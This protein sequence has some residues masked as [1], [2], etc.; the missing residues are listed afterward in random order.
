M[1][2]VQYLQSYDPPKTNEDFGSTNPQPF[3]RIR[4]CSESCE[5]FEGRVFDALEKGVSTGFC[6]IF[7]EQCF[8]RLLRMAL[9]GRAMVKKPDVWFFFITIVASK[10]VALS[11]LGRKWHQKR[12]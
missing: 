1:Q 11:A 5:H 7:A 9:F 3:Q 12:R 6:D 2:N 8:V 4:L 10:K